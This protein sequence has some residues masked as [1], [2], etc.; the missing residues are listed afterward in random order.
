[1]AI[2]WTRQEALYDI[3][4]VLQWKWLKS[5]G[6]RMDIGHTG[7]Q[8]LQTWTTLSM[9]AVSIYVVVAHELGLRERDVVESLLALSP[10]AL[11]I[12]LRPYTVQLFA[13]VHSIEMHRMTSHIE[14]VDREH[15]LRKGLKAIKL[16]YQLSSFTSRRAATSSEPDEVEESL[17]EETGWSC[18]A[19]L[20]SC[21]QALQCACA[22]LVNRASTIRTK[23]ELAREKKR[24]QHMMTNAS[25]RHEW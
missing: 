19:I 5:L 22:P 25:R 2:K 6:R 18:D 9:L 15:M 23:R 12:F 1:M 4:T 24:H 10:A 11:L 7:P 17:M 20:R 13:L 21:A 16:L 8:G 14:V 3:G